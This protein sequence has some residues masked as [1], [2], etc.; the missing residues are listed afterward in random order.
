MLFDNSNKLP[1]LIVE[2]EINEKIQIIDESLFNEINNLRY[3]K[4]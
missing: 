3:D 1:I 4:R 2:K